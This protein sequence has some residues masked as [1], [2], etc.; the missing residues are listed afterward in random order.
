MIS[1]HALHLVMLAY[2]QSALRSPASGPPHTHTSIRYSGRHHSREKTRHA[3]TARRKPT[4]ALLRRRGRFYPPPSIYLS[5]YVYLSISIPPPESVNRRDYIHISANAVSPDASALAMAAMGQMLGAALAGAG[6][7]CVAMQM[8]ATPTPAAVEA[9]PADVKNSRIKK[10][11]SNAGL[12]P[13]AGDKRL[14]STPSGSM[15]VFSGAPGAALTKGGG[16]M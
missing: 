5:I 3:L 7:A 1:F 16:E 4:S 12:Y 15:A 8:M 13:Q 14:K 9:M 10:T 6:V 2:T 11:L